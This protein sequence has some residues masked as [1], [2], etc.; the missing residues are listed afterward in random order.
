MIE[1]ARVA[2]DKILIMDLELFVSIDR[3]DKQISI[4]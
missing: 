4:S 3:F 1:L 2:N